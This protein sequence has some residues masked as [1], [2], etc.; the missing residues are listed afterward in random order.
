MVGH[1]GS[2][3]GGPNGPLGGVVVRTTVGPRH[4][5]NAVLTA[6]TA[7]PCFASMTAMSNWRFL[8][9]VAMDD[10]PFTCA[11]IST[12]INTRSG[13]QV[14]IIRGGGCDRAQ[15]ALGMH[16]QRT[17]FMFT[18]APRCT[19]KVAS[20]RW[21]AFTARCNGV[22]PICWEGSSRTGTCNR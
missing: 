22:L 11:I 15:G 8:H 10:A 18:S 16:V 19:I 13:S 4:K 7:A 5:I 17:S 3:W 6:S 20:A 14:S 9:A 21:P 1:S 12:I 2:E